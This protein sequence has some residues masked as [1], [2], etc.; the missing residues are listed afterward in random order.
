ML[1]RIV[2]FA[3]SILLALGW[4]VAPDL[5]A[6]ER[7]RVATLVHLQ[8]EGQSARVFS[9]EEPTLLLANPVHH[10]AARP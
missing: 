2:M 3:V 5:V 9:T 6:R 1:G 4:L 10:I 8:P 7:D